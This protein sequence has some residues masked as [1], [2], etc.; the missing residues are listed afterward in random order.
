M[1]D[2]ISTMKLNHLSFPTSDLPATAE[3][4]EKHLG[5]AIAQKVD[6]KYYI[7]KRPGFDVVIEAATDAKPDWPGTFHIGFELPSAEEVRRLYDRFK[8]DG[9]HLETDIFNNDR[10]SRFFC[11]APG[12]VMFEL[13]TRADAS[14]EYRGTFDN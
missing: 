14:N 3:F 6:E 2:T 9:V 10:G 1:I 7:L 4:F 13:N 11:R 12:G 5:F 8:A